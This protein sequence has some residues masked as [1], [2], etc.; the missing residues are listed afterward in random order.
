[1]REQWM[2]WGLTALIVAACSGD[3]TGGSRSDVGKNT[4]NGNGGANAASV[5]TGAD[6]SGLTLTNSASSVGG[7]GP[8]PPGCGDGILTDDEACD[9]ANTLNDDGCSANCLLVGAGY[10]CPIPGQACQAIAVCGDGIVA[11]SEICDD[12]NAADGDGCSST[13]KIEIGSKCEGEPS[14]CSPTT[15]GDGVKEGAEAC[16][17]GNDLPYDGCSATCQAE[18]NCDAGACTSTCGDGLLLAEEC[19]DGNNKSGD[20]CSETCTIEAGFICTQNVQESD[21]VNGIRVLRVPVLYRDF[22]GAHP[23][24]GTTKDMCDGWAPNMVATTLTNGVPTLADGSLACT[25][26]TT[27]ADWYSDGAGRTTVPGE[28]VLCDNN[29]GGFVN[30]YGPNCEQFEGTPNETIIDCGNGE[31]DVVEVPNSCGSAPIRCTLDA[32]EM[33]N[34]ANNQKTIPGGVLLDGTPLFFPLDGVAGAEMNSE[35][36][37]PEQ[38]AW[39]AWPWEAEVTGDSTSHNFYFTT[40]NGDSNRK[41]LE[42][43]I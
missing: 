21:M 20:G 39:N 35:A 40:E 11:T 2:A 15:C 29:I 25:N 1:M 34:A 33:C 37:I 6:A 36:R 5:A 17:D 8:A 30:R 7:G 18:P 43:Y 42:R 10:S 32:H 23:D 24:F 28:L 41:Y 22:T 3:G 27:F 12:M 13:C 26:A 16:D 38:Y 31:R 14:V 9:D 4:S 19:D